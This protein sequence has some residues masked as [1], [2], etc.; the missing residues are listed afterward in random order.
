VVNAATFQRGP[1]APGE[2]I[3]IFGAELGPA[4]LARG[5]FD[6][7]GTLARSVADAQITFDGIAAPLLYVSATQASAIV[8]YA[9][10]GKTSTVL[11]VSYRSK[12]TNS[13][14][15]AVAESAPGIFTAASSGRGQGA[16]LNQDGNLNSAANPA[17]LGSI[18]VLYATGEGQTAPGGVDGKLAAD[19]FPKPVLPVAVTIGGLEGEILYAGAAPGLVAGAMQVNVR[20]PAN[21]AVGDALPIRLRVGSNASP[22]G[23]TVAVR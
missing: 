10:A 13:I 3:T 20:V 21:A 22:E 7:A 15:L 17:A 2:I 19:V 1:V 23:V 4:E 12:K 5:A 9:L 11:Q 8:P 16:I 14:T 6:S 18:L